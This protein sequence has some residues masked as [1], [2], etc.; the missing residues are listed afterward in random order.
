MHNLKMVLNHS[1]LFS[2]KPWIYYVITVRNNKK[3]ILD[4]ISDQNGIVFN[5]KG[6]HDP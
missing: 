5:K 2:G 1:N 4:G 6:Y 3:V